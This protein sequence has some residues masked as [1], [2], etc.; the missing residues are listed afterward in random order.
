MLYSIN[1]QYIAKIAEISQALSVARCKEI[2]FLN[3]WL[4]K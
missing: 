3:Q 1:N 2:K 4:E